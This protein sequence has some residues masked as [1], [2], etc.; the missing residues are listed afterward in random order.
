MHFAKGTLVPYWC[1]NKVIFVLLCFFVLVQA[2]ASYNV[3]MR[4]SPYRDT[5]FTDTKICI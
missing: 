2:A 4:K 3:P 5:Q 1:L